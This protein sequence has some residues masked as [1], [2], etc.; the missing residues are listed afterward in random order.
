MSEPKKYYGKYRATVLNNVDPMQIGRIQA[1]VPD[2]SAV[3]PTSWAMPCVPIANKQAGVFVVPQ[4]G[5]GVWI[6]FEHGDP[7]YPIWVGG[8][9]GSVAEVPAFSLLGL[10]ADPPII[11]NT[12]LQNTVLLSDTPIGPMIG[13]G[14]LLM[15]G[16]SFI[17]I[18]PDGIQILAP[19]IQ[20]NGIT[21]INDG[22]LMVTP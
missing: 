8:Y 22:A 2:V 18:S 19:Q 21:I 17:T 20:I 12:T 11:L 10:P 7:D 13:P 6:E 5:D 9:W 14:V 4:I 3:L 1:T 16:A 15:S